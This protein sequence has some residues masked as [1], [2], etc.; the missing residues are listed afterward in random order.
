LLAGSCGGLQNYLCYS[1]SLLR[2][3][4]GG[5]GGGGAQSRAAG[6]VIA[7]ATAACVFVALSP[8]MAV[9]RHR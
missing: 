1:N 9:T 7:A 3:Q 4:C 6:L 8:A 5:G 2:H